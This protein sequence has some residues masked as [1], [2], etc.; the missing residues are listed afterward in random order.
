MIGLQHAPRLSMD[1]KSFDRVESMKKGD[2]PDPV[3]G[4][5]PLSA[6]PI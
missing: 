1:D 4:T 3:P 5:T 6:A 2:S